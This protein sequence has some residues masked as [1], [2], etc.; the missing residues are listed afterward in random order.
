MAHKEHWLD[1]DDQRM[2]FVEIEHEFENISNNIARMNSN[3][4]HLTHIVESKVDEIQDDVKAWRRDVDEWRRETD[5]QLK[6]IVH[7]RTAHEK[8][9]NS[10]EEHIKNDK[11]VDHYLGKWAL[12]LVAFVATIAGGFVVNRIL[13]IMSNN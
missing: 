6:D 1:P 3:V 9:L 8:M 7:C 5:S 11:P 13:N 10:F 12:A 4:E 2:S